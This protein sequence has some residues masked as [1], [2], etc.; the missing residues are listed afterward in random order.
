MNTLKNPLIPKE[1]EGDIKEL[2]EYFRQMQRDRAPYEN[3]WNDLTYYLFGQGAPTTASSTATRNGNMPGERNATVMSSAPY[4]ARTTLAGAL[5]GMVLTPGQRNR[6]ILPVNDDHLLRD[7]IMGVCDHLSNRLNARLLQ[8]EYGFYTKAHELLME[9]V[10]YGWGVMLAE[11]LNEEP[12]FTVCPTMQCYIDTDDW[13]RVDTVARCWEWSLL[14]LKKRFPPDEYPWP[15]SLQA[16][17]KAPG[18]ASQRVQMLHIAVPANFTR[19]SNMAGMKF[20]YVSIYATAT[21]EHV[22]QVKGHELFPFFVPRFNRLA[23]QKYPEGPGHLALPDIKSVNKL[24]VLNMETSEMLLHPPTV[25]PHRGWMSPI[26]HDPK[27][28]MYRD[29]LEG[30][31]EPRPLAQV[32]DGRFGMEYIQSREST[33]MQHFYVD[34]LRGP[35]KRAEVKEME[36]AQDQEE[37]LRDMAPQVSRLETEWLTPLTGWMLHHFGKDLL[38]GYPDALPPEFTGDVPIDLTVRYTSPIHR[39]QA[40][41]DATSIKR[42]MDQFLLP[43]ANVDP[44]VLQKLD[45]NEF[46][47][48][49]VERFNLPRR[50]RKSPE[51]EQQDMA[52]M[53]QQQEAAV[54]PDNILKASQAAKNLSQAQ[55]ATPNIMPLPP[56]FGQL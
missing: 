54:E 12:R 8:P 24:E 19:V 10:G 56:D 40:A 29:A 17:L 38:K 23:N 41:M 34:R 44:T 49:V 22:F 14:Q 52:A 51:R 39:A 47:D 5:L 25:L 15:P 28:V 20:P 4:L 33:I 31:L 36:L 11:P 30:D 3:A 6:E 26:K 21:M 7:D 43:I 1:Y 16:A 9:Y 35:N 46:V 32:G 45:Y 53:Q 18:G 37:R 55:A 2:Y 27:A 50:L 13:D 42:V 48:I